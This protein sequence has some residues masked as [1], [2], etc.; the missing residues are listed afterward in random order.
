MASTKIV[1]TKM[2]HKSGERQQNARDRKWAGHGG[3]NKG[4][5]EQK[6]Q[7]RIRTSCVL[8]PPVAALSVVHGLE[9]TR[10][11]AVTI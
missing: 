3:S 8:R 10:L 11:H 5:R 2:F 7:G 1:P 9:E 4:K 6:A